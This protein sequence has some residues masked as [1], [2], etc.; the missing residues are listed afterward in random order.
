L[1]FNKNQNIG[2]AYFHF[3]SIPSTHLY[4]L[5]MLSNEF[6][7]HGTV[8]S[9]DFQETGKG[10][11]GKSWFSDSGKKYTPLYYSLSRQSASIKTFFDEYGRLSGS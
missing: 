4:A 1:H 7:A 10:Q 2:S 5:E 9:A 11:M 8:I 6:P 3:N